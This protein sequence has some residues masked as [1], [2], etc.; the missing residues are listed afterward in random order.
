MEEDVIL[1]PP[2]W[3]IMYVDDYGQKHITYTKDITE[4]EFIEMRYTILDKKAVSAS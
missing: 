2:Y 3:F 1:F 4:L